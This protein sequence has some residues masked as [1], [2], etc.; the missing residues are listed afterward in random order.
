MTVETELFKAIWTK[1]KCKCQG[2]EGLEAKLVATSDFMDWIERSADPFADGKYGVTV[3]WS[4][5]KALKNVSSSADIKLLALSEINNL[6]VR[7]I[8]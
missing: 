7:N 3:R 5:L 1:G 6:G 8:G 4:M 2:T